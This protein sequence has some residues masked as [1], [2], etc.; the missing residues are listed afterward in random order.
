MKWP[1]D[2]Q[3]WPQSAWSRRVICPPH[4]WHVQE[5]G[6]GPLVL[7]LHG[8]GSATHSWAP[9]MADLVASHRVIAIDLPGHGFTALGAR[10]R[11][12]LEEMSED[13]GRLCAQEAWQPVLIV[14]H[15]AG[16]A[17]AM[18]LTD[19][20]LRRD[21]VAPPVLAVNP[22]MDTFE[23]PAGFVFPMIAKALSMNPMVP[24]LFTLGPD[25]MSRAR[26]LIGSTGS[27]IPEAQ[28]A[29]YARLLQD[30]DHVRGA[31][32]MMAQWSFRT[33]R[34][35]LPETDIRCTFV[36]GGKDQAVPPHQSQAVA[37]I[38][39]HAERIVLEDL[40][41]LAHEEA[42][43]RVLDVIRAQL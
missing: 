41:H 32:S 1:E 29:C 31:L 26:R 4:R 36:I 42:P 13:I 20:H 22:A 2:L 27:Q 28:L 34:A 24:W 40:G 30:R 16:G 10:N 15:S 33:L 23:G 14:A 12:G 8:A 38:L 5:A 37:L 7:F 18:D 21:G 9:V 19:R 11:S 43:E 17:V 35:R 3:N 39:K 25:A 6:E